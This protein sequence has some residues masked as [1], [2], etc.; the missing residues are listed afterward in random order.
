MHPPQTLPITALIVTKNESQRIV[1][2]IES[3]QG[4]VAEIWVIDS[5]SADATQDLA[6]KAGVHVISFEW[7]GQYPKKRQYILDHYAQDIP[8]SWL[9]WIDADELMT[10]QLATELAAINWQTAPQAGFF[11]RGRY[12]FEGQPLKHGLQNNKIALMHKDRMAF[13]PVDDL[14]IPAMGE[15]EGHYQPIKTP[16]H[17]HRAIGQ[18]RAPLLHDACAD[19][20]AWHARHA[21]Y[22]LWEVEMDRRQAWPQE[23]H[24]A[25]A[26][27]KA[28]F[29]RAP[30]WLKALIAFAHSYIL[31]RGFLDGGRGYRF[32]RLRAAYYAAAPRP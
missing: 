30:R 5:N 25:R 26:I 28:C 27:I 15:I 7:N 1:N 6:R 8:T 4:L 16:S 31:K 2:I 14:D 17:Q 18:M 3:L 11:I 21:R 9:L 32:A 12:I 10:P 20:D 24:K 22:A 13:P 23:D 29:R 19:M